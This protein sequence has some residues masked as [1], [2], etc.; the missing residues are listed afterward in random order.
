MLGP[1]WKEG[2]DMRNHDGPFELSLPD[3][4]AAALKLICYII[5]YQNKKVPRTLPAGDI[6]AVAVVADKYDCVDILK[7]ASESWLRT[8][9]D[10]PDNLMLLTAAAY[11]F[12]NAQAFNEITRALVLNYDGPYLALY[13]DEVESVMPWKAC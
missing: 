11:I 5:H 7:F 13:T 9:G 4:N 8:S 6:L 3:D 12:R 1:D 10:E 2:H